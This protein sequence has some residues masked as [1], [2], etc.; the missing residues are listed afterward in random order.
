M[1]HSVQKTSPAV[2]KEQQSFSEANGYKTSKI[3]EQIDLCTASKAFYSGILKAHLIF[4]E[5]FLFFWRS[6]M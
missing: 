4:E 5:N 3:P 2:F 1:C 6:A